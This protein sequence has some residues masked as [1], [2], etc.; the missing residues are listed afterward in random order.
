MG[1]LR[2]ARQARGSAAR[3]NRPV[4]R[5]QLAEQYQFSC[6]CPRCQREVEHDPLDEHHRCVTVVV[7]G[8]GNGSGTAWVGIAGVG[9][10]VCFGFA[11]LLAVRPNPHRPCQ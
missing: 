4:R 8:S 7:T 6:H 11:F 5:S 10:V 3:L 9:R 1:T 2:H